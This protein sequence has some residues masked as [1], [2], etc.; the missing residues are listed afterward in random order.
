MELTACM[1][2]RLCKIHLMTGEEA[3]GETLN[4]RKS[5]AELSLEEDEDSGWT[6]WRGCQ[7]ERCE[8]RLLGSAHTELLA[9]Q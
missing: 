2:L 9:G 5:A 7:G 8:G 1:Q 4:G 6:E 3:R